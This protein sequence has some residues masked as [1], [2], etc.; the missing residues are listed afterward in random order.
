MIIGYS[1]HRLQC[2]GNS[3][4]SSCVCLHAGVEVTRSLAADTTSF[5]IDGLQADSAYRVSVYTLAGSREGNPVSLN[6][7]TGTS[8]P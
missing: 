7:R 1:V 5:S 3:V 8:D 2:R 6:V 4:H